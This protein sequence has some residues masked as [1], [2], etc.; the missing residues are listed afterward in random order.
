VQPVSD[1]SSLGGWPEGADFEAFMEG[2]RL[3]RSEASWVNAASGDRVLV[4][5][6]VFSCLFRQDYRARL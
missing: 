2:V 4:D 6:D 3:A 1:I 5:T